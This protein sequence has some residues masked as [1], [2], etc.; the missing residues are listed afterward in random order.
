MPPEPFDA[1]RAIVKNTL[2]GNNIWMAR[3]PHPCKYIIPHRMAHCQIIW[4][5]FYDGGRIFF[6]ASGESARA[7]A[8]TNLQIS[9]STKFVWV[10]NSRLLFVLFGD[11]VK[12]KT[13]KT[14]NCHFRF[15]WFWDRR[16]ASRGFVVW[17]YRPER[18]FAVP[19][20][21]RQKSFFVKLG[22]RQII[23]SSRDVWISR[24]DRVWRYVDLRSGRR[25]DQIVPNPERRS[26]QAR[27]R[28]FERGPGRADSERDDDCRARR[29]VVLFGFFHIAKISFLS[30]LSHDTI[31]PYPPPH[32]QIKSVSCEKNFHYI[33][34]NPTR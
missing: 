11:R 22:H 33:P 26:R 10:C 1:S 15:F 20:V 30:I 3:L 18:R 16:D 17:P 27:Y 21:A 34:Q 28:G 8:R 31:I 9:K 5:F 32:C 6:A 7:C 25:P 14:R 19:P 29:L 24:L 4:D 2:G 12:V 13:G 23:R